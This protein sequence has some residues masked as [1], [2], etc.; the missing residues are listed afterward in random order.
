MTYSQFE[1]IERAIAAALQ[2]I[3]PV[4]GLL[5]LS[6]SCTARGVEQPVLYYA[7]QRQ[8]ESHRDPVD[9]RLYEALAD[10]MDYISGFCSPNMALYNHK[11]KGRPMQ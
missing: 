7:F 10:A 3:D 2:S 9:E 8:L 5:E 4:A 1:L 6:E 11:L